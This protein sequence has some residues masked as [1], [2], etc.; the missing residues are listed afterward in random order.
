MKNLSVHIGEVKLGDRDSELKVILGSCVGIALLW[1][2]ENRVALAHCLLPQGDITVFGGKYVNQAMVSL[3]Q[4]LEVK[5]PEFREL[6]AIIVGGA[7]MYHDMGNDHLRVGQLNGDAALRE[8]S[9][10]GINI[11][12]TDL[13]KDYGRQ[14]VIHGESWTYEVRILKRIA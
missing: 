1:K 10:R 13:G 9:A 6:E 8:V 11:I 12:H 14:L 3:I 7:N 5:P 2:K 4:I